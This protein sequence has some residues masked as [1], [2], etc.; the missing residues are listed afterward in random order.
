MGNRRAGWPSN[1]RGRRACVRAWGE[2]GMMQ[3]RVRGVYDDEIRE[4]MAGS[5]AGGRASSQHASGVVVVH[6]RTL[7]RSP[8]IPSRRALLLVAGRPSKASNKDACAGGS[9]RVQAGHQSGA[10]VPFVARGAFLGKRREDG[11]RPGQQRRHALTHSRR[12]KKPFQPSAGARVARRPPPVALWALP[13]PIPITGGVGPVTCASDPMTPPSRA[14][15]GETS[16]A[17]TPRPFCRHLGP[18]RMAPRGGACGGVS[19]PSAGPFLA[20]AC[21]S[22]PKVPD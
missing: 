9:C 13:D 7:S 22:I 2:P 6:S 5:S 18:A 1:L 17:S 14:L 10:V 3:R 19:G 15:E 4:L 11:T 21:P 20:G 12:A 16:A 8:Q